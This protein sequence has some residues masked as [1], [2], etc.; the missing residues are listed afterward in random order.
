M[1]KCSYIIFDNCYLLTP[2]HIE[3]DQSTLYLI[4]GIKISHDSAISSS[5]FQA[6]HLFNII[7][8]FNY[9]YLNW[10]YLQCIQVKVISIDIK[11]S[12]D[13]SQLF[14]ESCSTCKLKIQALK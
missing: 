7:K 11:V 9:L 3:F 14:K 6:H 4:K 13:I 12:E 5:Y 10:P 8:A 2:Q 1:R